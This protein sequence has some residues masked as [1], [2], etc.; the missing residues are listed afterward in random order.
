MLQKTDRP[1]H[2]SVVEAWKDRDA[3]DAHGMAAHTRQFHDRLAPMSGALYDER[4]HTILDQR[5]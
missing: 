1:N 2:F 5:R 4:L 3:F